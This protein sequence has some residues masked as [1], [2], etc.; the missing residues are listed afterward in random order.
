[1]GTKAFN[2]GKHTWEVLLNNLGTGSEGWE[3]IIGVIEKTAFSSF[4]DYHSNPS[5]FGTHSGAYSS[6]PNMSHTSTKHA[7]GDRMKCVLDCDNGTFA[8]T[9]DKGA[10][11]FVSGLNG[12]TLFPF[13]EM[14]YLNTS[15]TI[16]VLE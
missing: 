15:V 5:I 1:M 8:I 11:S 14:Y 3:A 16:K 13:I 12:K 4:G 6:S 10:N 9:S 2:K 7:I